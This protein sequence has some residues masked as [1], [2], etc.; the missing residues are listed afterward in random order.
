[1]FKKFL[2]LGVTALSM[3]ATSAIAAD[4]SRAR[5]MIPVQASYTGDSFG[6]DPETVSASGYNIQYVHSSGFG[7]GYT[8]TSLKLEYEG[9]GFLDFQNATFVDFSYL[10]GSELNGQ[11]VVG[12]LIGHGDIDQTSGAQTVDEKSGTAFGINGGYDFGGFEALLGYRS[13]SVTIGSDS[14]N[15]GRTLISAGIGFTF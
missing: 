8:S 12:T 5:L 4:A 6:S 2:I 13:E 1:M 15:V 9:G 14:T 11:I 7:V 3:V 10:F